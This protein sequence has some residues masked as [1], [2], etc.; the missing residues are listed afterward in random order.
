MN[1]D[2]FFDC[3]LLWYVANWLWSVLIHCDLFVLLQTNADWFKLMFIV[4]NNV[5]LCFF[6]LIW[7]ELVSL[8]VIDCLL[9]FSDFKCVVKNK[10]L[11]SCWFM[12]IHFKLCLFDFNLSSMI[13]YLCWLLFI[14]CVSFWFIAHIVYWCW[15]NLI[16]FDACYYVW[17][18][19]LMF[20]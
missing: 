6:M 15:L 20:Y 7:F 10:N 14:E 18:I 2:F 4:F 11:Y 8:V 3:Y 5:D 16:V 1:V 13:C 12:C 9:V 17:L 19:S